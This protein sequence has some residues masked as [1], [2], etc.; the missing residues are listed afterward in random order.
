MSFQ[1]NVRTAYSSALTSFY[2]SLPPYFYCNSPRTNTLRAL[3]NVPQAR[4]KSRRV[5]HRSQPHRRDSTCMRRDVVAS[6][7]V[8][9]TGRHGPPHART[10]MIFG[11]YTILW[12]AHH[13]QVCR[14]HAVCAK[15]HTSPLAPIVEN[16]LRPNR[17]HPRTRPPHGTRAQATATARGSS[18]LVVKAENG[19][20]CNVVHR[21]CKA[22]GDGPC[23]RSL[24]RSGWMHGPNALAGWLRNAH[25][26]ADSALHDER[27]RAHRAA[28]CPRPATA[29]LISTG[30]RPRQEAAPRTHSATRA[31]TVR[32]RSGRSAPRAA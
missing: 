19:A 5:A 17:G 30:H 2:L 3:E 22:R 12:L 26:A 16:A 7:A 24:R 20:G 1:V 4:R 9:R 13:H 28:T 14:H 10:H 25:C 11:L 6:T 32:S 15:P 29:P 18:S 27:V 31:H 21:G 8:W 23:V